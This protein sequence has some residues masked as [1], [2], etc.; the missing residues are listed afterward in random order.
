MEEENS[1]V[2]DDSNVVEETATDV[3]KPGLSKGAKIGISIAVVVGIALIIGLAVGLTIGKSGGSGGSVPQSINPGPPG[4][5]GPIPTYTNDFLTGTIVSGAYSG[6]RPFA[7]SGPFSALLS[8]F[9]YVTTNPNNSYWFMSNCK[10]PSDATPNPLQIT[11][12][13][14]D[15][16]NDRYIY[17]TPIGVTGSG[18]VNYIGL[19]F[20]ISNTTPNPEIVAI[21]RGTASVT[22]GTGVVTTIFPT[23]IEYDMTQCLIF[24]QNSDHILQPNAT[25]V[26]SSM[27]GPTTFQ[28]GY[29]NGTLGTFAF[30][31]YVVAKKQTTFLNSSRLPLS[32]V[33]NVNLSNGNVSVPT[34]TTMDQTSAHPIVFAQLEGGTVTNRGVIQNCAILD[35]NHINIGLSGAAV[36]GIFPVKCFVWNGMQNNG[37]TI[38][39]L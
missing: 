27:F 14:M 25:I 11:S 26:S 31:W 1:L 34:P 22:A 7:V 35:D 4:P 36:T 2:A 19:G 3:V 29:I 15:L 20:N 17:S 12:S 30:V 24:V 8:P 32:F 10:S 37:F 23:P 38:N 28:F 18:I 6:T 13:K 5:P 16:T 9:V 33:T 21:G 39:S